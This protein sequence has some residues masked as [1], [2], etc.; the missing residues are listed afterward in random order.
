[1]ALNHAQMPRHTQTLLSSSSAYGPQQQQQQHLLANAPQTGLAAPGAVPREPPRLVHLPI[2][3][4]TY[5]VKQRQFQYQ[6]HG[7]EEQLIASN[8]NSLMSGPPSI[9]NYV[10]PMQQLQKQQHWQQ[11]QQHTSVTHA[12]Y[13]RENAPY[14]MRMEANGHHIPGTYIRC[15]VPR[16]PVG[17]SITNGHPI[18]RPRAAMV[19]HWPRPANQQQQ[20]MQMPFKAFMQHGK[21]T[22]AGYPNK[23][24]EQIQGARHFQLGHPLHSCSQVSP[25]KEG[26]SVVPQ[27]P[28]SPRNGAHFPSHG[29]QTSASGVSYPNRA[30]QAPGQ[31]IRMN[32]QNAHL[33]EKAVDVKMQMTATG[34]SQSR[35]QDMNQEH[36]RAGI[37][38]ENQ[39]HENGTHLNGYPGHQFSPGDGQQFQGRVSLGVNSNCVEMMPPTPAQPCDTTRDSLN[40]CAVCR[41]EASFLCSGC[42]DSWYC[43]H[44]CQNQ[45]WPLH[46]SECKR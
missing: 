41:R 42:K 35:L 44:E 24:A 34:H 18:S 16:M 2:T 6:C 17:G 4:T 22:M 19:K 1:M 27:T 32:M 13:H 23:M 33:P 11:L 7:Q 45:A 46:C 38:R 39:G 14:P 12:T 15:P 20:A 37:R 26:I 3:D 28:T 30:M 9:Q 8:K 25:R 10:Q 36:F 29:N 21:E 5:E 31:F 43:S 40:V